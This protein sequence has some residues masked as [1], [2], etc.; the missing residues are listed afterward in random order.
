MAT[1]YVASWVHDL[2]YSHIP[3]DVIRSA[4]RSFYNWAG[5]AIGGSDHEAVQITVSNDTVDR[6]TST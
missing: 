6:I 1:K 4:V 5:C 2:E 3:G